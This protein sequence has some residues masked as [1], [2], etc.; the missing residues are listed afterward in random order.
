MCERERE[1]I[2]VSEKA[3]AGVNIFFFFLKSKVFAILSNCL[4]VIK[5]V[6]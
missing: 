6:R 1:G 3:C 5:R 2:R 4:E